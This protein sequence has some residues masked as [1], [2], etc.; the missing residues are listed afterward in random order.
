MAPG[1][2]RQISLG[3]TVSSGLAQVV[4]AR[5]LADYSGTQ[6]QGGWYYGYYDTPGNSPSFTQMSFFTGNWQESPTFPPYTYLWNAGGLPGGPPYG[7]THWAV[8]RWVSD[9]AGS[10]SIDGRAQ[11]ADYNQGDGVVAR[12]YVDGVQVWAHTFGRF[13]TSS[14]SFQLT[15]SVQVGST[16]DFVID[17]IDRIE[18]DFMSFTASISR[19]MVS[20]VQTLH[21]PALTVAAEHIISLDQATQSTD[22][23][24]QASYTLELTNPFPA[25]QIYM[26]SSDGLA[27]LTTDLPASVLVPAGQT[28]SL[29][30]DV[31]VPTGTVPGNHVFQ[32]FARTAAGATDSVEGQLSV[33]SEVALKSLAVQMALQPLQPLAGQDTPGTF[34]ARVT[35]VGDSTDNYNLSVTGLPAGIAD[36]MSQATITVPPGQSNFRDIQLMLTP[37]AGTIPGAY[38]FTITAV[39]TTDPTVTA[40]VRG[41][42]TVLAGSV[43][44]TLTPS[45]GAPG[46]TFQMTVT[47]T[48]QVADTFNLALTGPA[49]VAA[50]LGVT[51]VS[52][53]PGASQVFPITTGA[54]NFADPG[55]LA[56]TAV[57][58]SQ[59]NPAI[60]AAATANLVIPTFQSMTADSVSVTVTQVGPTSFVLLVHNTG[61]IEDAYTATITGVTG[62]VTA[63]LMGLDG[64]PAQ[65]IPTFRLPGLFTGAILVQADV[66]AAGQGLVTVRISSASNPAITATATATVN[67]AFTLATPTVTATDAGGTYN[68]SAFAASATVTGVGNDGTLASSPNPALTYTYYVGSSAGGNGS[69]TAPSNAGTYTVVAHYSGNANYSA[70][71]SAPVTFTINSATPT[72]TANG[73]T[74]MYDGQGHTATGSV[75]GN[76]G[77]NLGT[78]TFTYTRA[79]VT[80]SNPPIN[81]GTYTV[82]ASFASNSNYAQAT[83]T[84]TIIINPATPTVTATD[85]GGTYNGNTFTASAT[86]AGIG[87]DGTLATSPNASLTFTY[88]VGSSATGTGSATAPV[89]AGTYTVVAHY[90]GGGNYAG[91]DSASVTFN[92]AKATLMVTTS[93]TRSFGVANPIFT[94]S[95]SGFVHGE[96]LATSGVTG[97]PSLSTSASAGSALGPYPITVGTGTLAA[98]NYAF[99]LVNGT[100]TVTPA[101]LSATGVNISATA[102]ASFSG[103]VATFV[104]AD[105]FGGAS[106]YSAL[107]TWGDGSTSAGTVSGTGSTL[108]VSGTH[109]FAV[110]GSDPVQVQISHNLGY[111]TTATSSSTATVTGTTTT[112]HTGGIGFWHNKNG[113]ALISSFNGGS[114]ATALSSWLATNFP[115]LYGASAGANNLT[116]KTNAQVATFYLT[117]FSLNG[118]KVEAKT[119]A[120]ALN[121]YATTASLGGTTG[122]GSGFAVSAA[123]QGAQ[124]VNVGNNGAAFGVANNNTLTIYQLLQAVNR[125]AVNGVLY[126]RSNNLRQQAA[127]LFD[128]LG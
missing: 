88:Y 125:N 30:L 11:P 39:S 87:A 128:A 48:G 47:N 52:L 34:T 4:T 46:S 43:Q 55:A 126:A 41:T 13:D 56:L 12:V 57:A 105:P 91:A 2:V 78:P 10:V 42:V 123:G 64:Q 53:P 115:N 113:Q 101:P 28:I 61:N 68:G 54:I 63:R 8:R 21:L 99:N 69:A 95:Y 111:T 82:T 31:M 60:Q 121:V 74:F 100:L 106:S 76:H 93:A 29:P 90:A 102:G 3:T 9:V 108:S 20:N 27:G 7:P 16:V 50:N 112:D 59:L 83:N 22:R 94:A 17:P 15:Q 114:T 35:N 23:G 120:A 71:A 89:N 86:A 49:A 40:T 75:V 81:S 98:G 44:V 67:T 127:D 96:T 26:L 5:S 119:L 84:A 33:S 85:N 124:A 14:S 32:V 70:A 107:I 6:G 79:G 72:V 1:E 97:N 118:P 77:D 62:P 104:N 58:T 66:L 92:I 65:T 110:A 37:A 19:T 109:I 103:T 45:S 38:P 24:S 73:G 36:S 116:G 18:D 25:A 51:A 122:V 80:S 117:Q